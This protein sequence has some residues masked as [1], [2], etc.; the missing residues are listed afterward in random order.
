M[1][2]FTLVTVKLQN[3]R[4]FIS[5]VETIDFLCLLLLIA[6]VDDDVSVF[7]KMNYLRTTKS[8]YLTSINY[9]VNYISLIIYVLDQRSSLFCS[10]FF[11]TF[12]LQKKQKQYYILQKFLLRY[13]NLKAPYVFVVILKV[14]LINDSSKRVQKNRNWIKKLLDLKDSLFSRNDVNPK[15]D[16]SSWFSHDLL[17]GS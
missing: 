7:L 1:E 10:V 3:K 12:C 5:F 17:I 4:D 13:Q 16:K 14:F 15:L 6:G 11:Q 2:V 8:S 9:E